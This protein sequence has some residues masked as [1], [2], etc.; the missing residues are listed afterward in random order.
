MFIVYCR[1]ISQKVCILPTFAALWSLYF[2]LI[3]VA[4]VF[5][6]QCDQLLLEAGFLMLLLAPLNATKRS[7]PSD[8]IIL[9]LVRWLVFRFLFESGSVKLVSHCPKWWSF[10]GITFAYWSCNVYKIYLSKHIFLSSSR[11]PLWSAALANT[12]QLVRIQP[13]RVLVEGGQHFHQPD[14]AGLRVVFLLSP[15]HR[16]A[17]PVLLAIVP[18]DVD[19]ADGQLWIFEFLDASTFAFVIGRWVFPGERHQSVGCGNVSIYYKR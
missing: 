9:V 8:R 18:T 19:R 11:P 10:T 15:S 2:S 13:T 7:S 17:I 5:G 4:D 14:G 3:Q 1:L 16:Q 6:N 12:I